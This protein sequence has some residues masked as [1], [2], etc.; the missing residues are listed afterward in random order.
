MHIWDELALIVQEEYQTVRV[1]IFD[2]QLQNVGNKSEN[3]ALFL[4]L[5]FLEVYLFSMH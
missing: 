3:I 1:N 5:L 2:L 4:L